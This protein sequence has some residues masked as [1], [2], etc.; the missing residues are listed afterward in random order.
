MSAVREAALNYGDGGI[1]I[2]PVHGIVD[3]RCTCGKD[4][5]GPDNRS[6]GKHPIFTGSFHEA[7]TDREQIERWWAAHPNANIGTSA[8]DV[9]DVDHYKD[10]AKETARTSQRWL[11]TRSSRVPRGR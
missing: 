6:A 5:C 2:F 7:S 1:A 8:F 11:P 3:G 10:G 4:P 9:V